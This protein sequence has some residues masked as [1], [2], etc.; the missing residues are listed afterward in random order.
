MLTCYSAV[1]PATAIS[2]MHCVMLCHVG[3]LT[4]RTKVKTHCFDFMLGFCMSFSCLTN[5][6]ISHTYQ[7]IGSLLYNISGNVNGLPCYWQTFCVGCETEHYGCKCFTIY[8]SILE[9]RGVGNYFCQ[10]L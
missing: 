4:E 3:E 2:T 1:I 8:I 6:A 7:I 10:F 5:R 9:K